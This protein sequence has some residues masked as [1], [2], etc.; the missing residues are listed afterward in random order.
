MFKWVK[1]LFRKRHPA[2][3]NIEIVEEGI[4]TNRYGKPLSELGHG[5]YSHVKL[6]R[7]SKTDSLVAIK[8]TMSREY[9]S[10][11][12]T[13]DII[14]EFVALKTLSQQPNII[15]MLSYDF[16]HSPQRIALEKAEY[17][18]GQLIAHTE[19]TSP[20]R[21]TFLRQLL[22]A[23]QLIHSVG[24]VHRDI[25]PDNCLI[26]EDGRLRLADFGSSRCYHGS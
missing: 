7:D 11:D 25:K 14:R 10:Y 17:S 15:R 18:L 19:L 26:L 1:K 4:D 8:T 16:E 12:L 2:P 23:V 5:S 24:I 21:E 6:H 3:Q 13:D 20:E 22:I 9:K